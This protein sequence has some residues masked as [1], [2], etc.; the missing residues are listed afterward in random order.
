MSSLAAAT[1]HSAHFRSSRIFRVDALVEHRI[2]EHHQVR[3]ED[4]AFSCCAP[5]WRAAALTSMSAFFATSAR[6][7][8]AL[9]LLFDLAA[10]DVAARV[11][12][13]HVVED[14]RRADGDAGRSGMPF[15][16]MGSR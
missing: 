7:V 1:A 12:R 3:V 14:D 15:R 16:T 6:L 5:P 8:D 13:A 4:G 10:V 2:A 11:A 9:D